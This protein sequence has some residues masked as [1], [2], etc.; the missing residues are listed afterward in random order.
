LPGTGLS[1][2]RPGCLA[3]PASICRS[4]TSRGLPNPRKA[5]RPNDTT[6]S[7][8]PR[9]QPPAPGPGRRRAPLLG[10]WLLA[11]AA[12]CQAVAARPPGCDPGRPGASRYLVL[13]GQVTADTAVESAQHPLREA[14]ELAT[15]PLAFA[16]G[17]TACVLYKRLGL[18]LLTE[19]PPVPPCRPALD[20]D[21][22]EEELRGMAGDELVPA[23]A[24]LHVRGDEALAAL[25]GVIDRATTRIDVLMY[26]WDPDPVGEQVASW[27]AA[28]AG[29]ALRV[30]VVVDGGGNLIFGQPPG[31]SV[32]EVNRVVCWLARHPH[33]ELVRGRN[34][35][36]RFDHRKLVVAD[37]CLAWSGGRNF[38]REAFSEAHDAS[39][40]LAGPLAAEMAADFEEYWR[41]QGGAPAPPLP[42]A[43]APDPNAWARLVRTGPGRRELAGAL[44][45]AVDRAGHHVYLENPYFTDP[46]LLRKLAV[47]RRRGVDVRVVLTLH[48]GSAVLDRSNRVTANRL[49]GAGVRVYLYP[50][51]THMKAASVDGVWAYLGTGNFDP[52]SLRHDRE[53]G[54]AVGA[55]EFLAELEGRVLLPDLRPEWELTGPLPVTPADYAAEVLAGLF[56]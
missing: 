25:R 3:N 34:G 27:L 28:R 35:C 51:T 21:A 18:R 4:H 41:E 26:E 6:F 29:P 36:A 30:R 37:G 10:P 16:R 54:L 50:G 24:R 15:E 14:V 13:A 5:P 2:A 56:L 43:P 23:A 32:A 9:R 39:Y 45:R 46:V 31:A 48:S 22:L 7:P 42:P 12:G 8:S 52:L 20:P 19:P 44:Y 49:L 33:V 40:T 11:V 47:A 17:V 1:P 38:T 55:G 53:L